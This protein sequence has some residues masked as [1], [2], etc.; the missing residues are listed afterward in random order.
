MT[1]LDCRNCK[2]KFPINKKNP[3]QTSLALYPKTNGKGTNRSMVCKRGQWVNTN[4]EVSILYIEQNIQHAKLGKSRYLNLADR[5]SFKD[6]E[7]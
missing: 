4:G 3:L 1:C 5:C 6:I 2:I 7:D